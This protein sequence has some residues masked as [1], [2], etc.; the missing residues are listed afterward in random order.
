[1]YIIWISIDELSAKKVLLLHIRLTFVDIYLGGH[2]SVSHC[3]TQQTNPPSTHR[4][5]NTSPGCARPL[6]KSLRSHVVQSCGNI[7]KRCDN[8]T[9]SISSP[10]P[11]PTTF[12]AITAGNPAQGSCQGDTEGW[13]WHEASVLCSGLWLRKALWL[14]NLGLWSFPV[15]NAMLKWDLLRWKTKSWSGIR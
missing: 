13:V 11:H 9:K 14:F 8:H 12:W 1:M 6:I 7:N 2:L 4:L 3:V 5:G 10:Q 15:D